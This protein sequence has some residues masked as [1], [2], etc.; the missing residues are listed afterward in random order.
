[1]ENT[2]ATLMMNITNEEDFYLDEVLIHHNEG[3]D[4]IPSN[5]EY[6]AVLM[7]KK[8]AYTEYRQA[9]KEMQDYLIAKQNVD[10]ILHENEKEEKK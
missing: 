4:M 7:K 1:M 2:L 10:A 5:E 8:K 6:S 9:K 3:V